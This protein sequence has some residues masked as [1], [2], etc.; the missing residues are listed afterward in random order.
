MIDSGTCGYC[1]GP[2]SMRTG[3]CPK[4][5][6]ERVAPGPSDATTCSLPPAKFAY[7][8]KVMVRCVEDGQPFPA[9]VSGIR[10]MRGLYPTI[11]YTVMLEDGGEVDG[12]T[13]EWLSEANAGAVT[14]G[15][16]G[17]PLK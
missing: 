6:R 16:K 9:V 11:D 5:D 4:C 10:L 3:L 2:V 8:Q 14:P 17:E 13:D 12:Y 1:H 15:E 7:G